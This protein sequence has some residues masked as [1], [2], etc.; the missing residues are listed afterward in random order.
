MLGLLAD[1]VKQGSGCLIMAKKIRVRATTS[2]RQ[3]FGN[4]RSGCAPW[5]KHSPY[6]IPM[7]EGSL[8]PPP[9]LELEMSGGG[10]VCQHI[11]HCDGISQEQ[12]L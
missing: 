11:Q 12:N 1:H 9:S 7:P 8:H 4:Q 10:R 3:P 5:L 6:Q 2:P